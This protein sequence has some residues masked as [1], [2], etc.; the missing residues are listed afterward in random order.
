MCRPIFSPNKLIRNALCKAFFAFQVSIHYVKKPCI[1]YA[2]PMFY[3][4]S[5]PKLDLFSEPRVYHVAATCVF[6]YL[7]RYLQGNKK[8]N[9]SMCLR[10]ILCP[11]VKSRLADF[12]LSQF[13]GMT[14]NSTFRKVL[15]LFWNLLTITYFSSCPVQDEQKLFTG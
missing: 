1:S 6:I 5:K 7:Q 4:I 13:S 15:C 3:K 14:A 8:Q 2:N 11:L 12:F 9:Y 10:S